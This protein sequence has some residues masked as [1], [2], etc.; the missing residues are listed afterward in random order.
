MPDTSKHDALMADV[1]KTQAESAR[2]IAASK[3]TLEANDPG[4][5]TQGPADPYRNDLPDGKPLV[6]PG[7]SNNHKSPF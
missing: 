2:L 1:A 4:S 5:T 6:H 7:I 3:A